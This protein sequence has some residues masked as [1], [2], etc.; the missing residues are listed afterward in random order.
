MSP[1]LQGCGCWHSITPAQALQEMNHGCFV[2]LEE[3]GKDEGAGERGKI[4]PVEVKPCSGGWGC[5]RAAPCPSQ[6]LQFLSL[7]APLSPLKTQ[8]MTALSLG[9]PGRG[10]GGSSRSCHQQRRGETEDE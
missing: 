5:P 3:E 4:E 2:F 6:V 1:A 8:P 9:T 10:A 7:P